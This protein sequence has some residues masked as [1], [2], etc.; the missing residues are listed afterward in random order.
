MEREY[1]SGERRRKP[2]V[3]LGLLQPREVRVS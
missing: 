1:I 3:G 2:V